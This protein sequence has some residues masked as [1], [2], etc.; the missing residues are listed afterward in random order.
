[1]TTDQIR[2]RFLSFFQKRG[3]NIVASD[4]LIPQHDPTLLFTGAGMN[5]FKDQFMGRN[6]SFNRAASC[7]KCLRTADLDKVGKTAG[8]HTFFEMLGNFS[9]GDY[10]KK[11]AIVWAWEFLTKELRLPEERLW[12]SVYEGDDEAYDIWKETVKISE[13]RIVKLGD[14]ENFWPSE[15][16]KNGP[17]GPCGPSSEIFYD[18]GKDAGC[19]KKECDPSCDC[20]RFIEIWNLVFTQFNRK[21]GGSL[22]PLPK[23]NI[24]TGMGLERLAAVMQH[25]RS[26]FGIDIFIYII[27]TITK[28]LNA[29]YGKDR[30]AD[31]HIN[32]IADHIR[33]VTF[34]ISD[35]VR[36]SNESR[37]FVIRKLVR[38]A[39]ER[40]RAL[41]RR[42]PF[43]YKIVPSMAKAM[44]AAYPELIERREDIAEVVLR[45]EVNLEEILNTILP[46]LEEEIMRLKESGRSSVPGELIFRYY[47]EKGIPLDLIEESAKEAGL[48]ADLEGFDKLLKEQKARSRDK[49]KVAA[50]IFIEKL[51]DC[52][53]KTE[54]LHEEIKAEAKV[55]AILKELNGKAERVDRA[56]REDAVHIALDVTPFYGE[57]GGQAGDRGE[58]L[59]SGLKIAVYDAKKY[60]D[61]IDHMGKVLE[62]S[63]KMGDRV[64]ARIDIKRR[65][66]IKKNHTATHILHSV[67]KKV[68]GGHVRQFGSLVE[69]EKLRFDFTHPAK[70]EDREIQRVEEEINSIIDKDL[71]VYTAVMDLEDA[72][73]SGAI[74]LF[75]QKYKDKVMV[76]TIGDVSKELCGGTHVGKT[77]EIKVFKILNESSIASG[78]RRIE[79]LT[80]SAVYGWLKNDVERRVSEYRETLNLVKKSIGENKITIE[81]IE[82]YLAPVIFKSDAIIKKRLEGFDRKDVDS[83]TKELRPEF[84]RTIEDLSKELKKIKKDRSAGRLNILRE[85][86]DG[87]IKEA[88][89]IGDV[90]VILRVIEDAD[91]KVLRSLM[92][93][94]KKKAGSTIVLFGS[95]DSSKAN[96]VCGVTDDLVKR[97]FDASEI[98]KKVASLIDG[99]GGGRPDM[100]Q[101]GGRNPDRLKE[102]LEDGLKIIEERTR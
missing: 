98:I 46:H 48:T 29:K 39:S 42:E 49:S 64:E 5:Q 16:K 54:F 73:K 91:M 70:M 82:E 4:L 57:A 3:H 30:E 45:E 71:P 77:G 19:G 43:M 14:K 97:G 21:E 84:L 62:G 41:G 52:D 23:K 36:P 34:A 100:A 27:R 69:E 40:A 31:S 87:F 9:F 81:K 76:R 102:A 37:G 80:G 75:G 24:D 33:A 26:N 20:G 17:N 83:W 44:K 6:I 89:S 47:D 56:S 72:K 58:I 92:D 68:L 60:E 85:D 67:L 63:V 7:Q 28:E 18:W 88:K 86:I 8:H 55:L 78:V 101:A 96:I 74:A 1:M 51:S 2:T 13:E 61:T 79:A 32:A 22:E 59:K 53:L 15:V 50:S 12:A 25:K 10:F 95:R 94:V 65:D 11:D 99:S 90:R 66:R 35:G 38:K 93:S